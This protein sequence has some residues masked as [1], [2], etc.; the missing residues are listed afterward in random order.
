MTGTNP[1]SQAPIVENKPNDREL[2]FRALQAKYEK[3]LSEERSAR[4]EAEKENQR[5][6][7]SRQSV[8][9]D[10]DSEP[11]VDNKKLNKKL[12]SYGQQAKQ[13]TQSEIQKAV[14]VAIQEERKQ[15]W[16]KSNS[17]F[18][19]VLQYAEK[20]AQEDPELAE[21]I[22]TMPEGFERQKLVYKNIKA[23]GIHKDPVKQPTIQDR[24]D[25]NKKSPFYQ[26]TGT[27][28]APYAGTAANFSPQGQ[29]EA[30][31]KMKELQAR[32]RI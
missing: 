24:I 30:H 11:Y 4:M 29:K 23:L 18:Y 27:G 9:D 13:E 7:S 12:A 26:P 2:N 1:Q 25:A 19:E 8:D 6:M 31:A 14:Q 16:L 22:L 15:N 20:F 3:Q 5:L 17:D 32:L 21:T 28:S 10:E